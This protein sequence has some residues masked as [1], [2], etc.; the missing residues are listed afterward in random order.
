MIAKLTTAAIA[1]AMTLA[2][3][4]HADPSIESLR[5]YALA[6]APSVCLTV[7]RHGQEGIIATAD[8]IESETG[9]TE[10]EAGEVI[11]IAVYSSCP[12]FVPVLKQFAGQGNPIG[13][14]EVLA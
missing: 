1:T 11:G 10:Y 9:W 8:A 5:G 3:P 2:A 4:A 12:Q 14:G 6:I 13:R 7:G